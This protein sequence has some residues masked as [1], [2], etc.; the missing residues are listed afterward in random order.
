MT[1]LGRLLN[2]QEQELLCGL[3]DPL[4]E[5]PDADQVAAL[6]ADVLFE[7]ARHHNIEP[8]LVR[9]LSKLDLSGFEQFAAQLA[10]STRDLMFMTAM[11]M[12]LDDHSGKIRREMD[13]GDL[14]YAV[15][16]GAAFARDL[17]PFASDRPYSDIDILLPTESLAPAM[18]IMTSL[19]FEQHKRTHFDKSEA[20]EEQKWVLKDNPMLLVELHTNLVHFRAL[21]KRISLSYEDYRIAGAEGD[22]PLA[23][24]FVLAVM[25]AAAG[26]KFHQL[27]LLV[28]V[29]QASRALRDDDVAHIAEVLPYLQI[30]PEISICLSLMDALFP[31]MHGTIGTQEMRRRFDLPHCWKPVDADAVLNAPYTQFW[32]SK[33][34][35]HAFRYYQL[36]FA[37]R[38]GR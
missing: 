38:P 25:H 3:A 17:Y 26:H 34:R 30:H 11:T 23:G 9:K 1:T 32:R 2:T 8:V 27:R 6:D 31:E 5:P 36:T 7:A 10:Q 35:R 19:G 20:N 15:V 14:P 24:H 4:G 18:D 28:D 29:L 13:S 12:A 37:S 16:K 33:I 21:R 22:R